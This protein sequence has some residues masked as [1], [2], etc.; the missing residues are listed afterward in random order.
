MVAS[1]GKL[2]VL[3][4]D[5]EIDETVLLGKLIAEA[6]AVVIDAEADVH[7]ASCVVLGET[8]EKLVVVV[9]DSGRLAP[10]GL[11]GLVEG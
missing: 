8:D 4:L 7:L 10:D 11:P 2:R 1:H 9:A 6:H 3:L 5:D